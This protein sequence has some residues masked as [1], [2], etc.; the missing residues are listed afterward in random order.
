MNAAPDNPLDLI[1]VAYLR[2][3]D[4]I[5]QGFDCYTLVRFV[6]AYYY[7]RPTPLAAPP[8]RKWQGPAACAL[9]MHHARRA[10][11]TRAPLWQQCEPH[12]GCVVGLARF[13]VERLHHCG[14]LIP[15][16]VLHAMRDA[17][18]MLTPCAR[19]TELFAQVEYL[20]CLS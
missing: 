8:A 11:R 13:K 12:L 1:G 15:E 17:G 20:E 5:A 4:D 14:V 18:V 10:T 7:G 16:G 19:L 2:G 3:S 6:R 9:G